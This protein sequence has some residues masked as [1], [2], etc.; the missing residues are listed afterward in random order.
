MCCTVA[1]ILYIMLRLELLIRCNWSLNT[2]LM[3]KL[4]EKLL[5]ED[6]TPFKFLSV[7]SSYC[8]IFLFFTLKFQIGKKLFLKFGIYFTEITGRNFCDLTH[9][10]S[11]FVKIST[12]KLFDIW[13]FANVFSCRNSLQG[14]ESSPYVLLIFQLVKICFKKVSTFM[15]LDFKLLFSVLFFTEQVVGKVLF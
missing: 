11:K 15:I 5:S 12:R 13:P 1:S 10:F 2:N 9:F 4:L 6:L 7:F 3:L 14:W 8:Y